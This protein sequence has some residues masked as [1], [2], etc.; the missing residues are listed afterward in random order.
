[1]DHQFMNGDRKRAGLILHA[2]DLGDIGID[3]QGI[4]GIVYD[5]SRI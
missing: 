2:F 5:E 1:M 4:V 3:H